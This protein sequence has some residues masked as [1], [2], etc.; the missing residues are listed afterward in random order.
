VE[1]IDVAA[2][3]AALGHGHAPQL[4][5]VRETWE[6]VRGSIEPS[7]HVP[8]GELARNAVGSL[9]ALDPALPTVVYC[10][11]GVRSLH[12]A[13]ILRENHG[14]RN[15]LSLRGGYHAWLA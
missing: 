13:R 6:R 11:A 14:F 4:I 5:D 1:E 2:L 7:V 8:V 9:A 12:G 3:R 10:A 15:V